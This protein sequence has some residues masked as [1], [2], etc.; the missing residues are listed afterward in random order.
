MVIRRP[1]RNLNNPVFQRALAL[2]QQR[3]PNAAVKGL[4]NRGLYSMFGAQQGARQ[5]ASER[6]G[7][8]HAL[9]ER[10]MAESS[11]QFDQTSNLRNNLFGLQY[12]AF[13][14][15]K[16]GAKFAKPLGL[17]QLGLGIKGSSDAK[18]ARDEDRASTQ[19]LMNWFQWQNNPY[20]NQTSRR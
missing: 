7:A 12:K 18:K 4:Q 10:Q 17:I 11:R 8:R 3:N 6:F 15:A 20:R 9:R 16:K 14:D 19:K 2:N 1:I 13:R 5:L